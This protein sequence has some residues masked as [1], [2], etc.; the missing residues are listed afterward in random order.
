MSRMKDLD[1][2]LTE[3][4]HWHEQHEKNFFTLQEGIASAACRMDQL[5]HLMQEMVGLE[6]R[7]ERMEAEIGKKLDR[8]EASQVDSSKLVDRLIEMSMVQQGS[9]TEAVT[10]R[11]QSRLEND[12]SSQQSWVEDEEEGDVWP[13]K[14]SDVMESKG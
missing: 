9:A 11:A 13:P 12:F 10:H 4:Y 5:L 7:I 1:M 6:G 2:R 14:N 3:L 8:M